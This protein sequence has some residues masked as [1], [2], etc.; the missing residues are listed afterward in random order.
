[1]S[2]NLMPWSCTPADGS[3][4]VAEGVAAGWLLAERVSGGMKDGAARSALI[5]FIT[6]KSR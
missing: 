4:C 5:I 3:A 1:M 6:I 2:A